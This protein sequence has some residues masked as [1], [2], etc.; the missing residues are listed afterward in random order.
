VEDDRDISQAG[1][2]A[3][4]GSAFN[5]K[6][7]GVSMR[8]FKDA[9]GREWKIGVTV[10]SVKRVK[11][12]AKFDL[13]RVRD[14][15]VSLTTDPELLANVLCAICRPQ[16]E[17]LGISDEEFGEGL[18]GDP[19]DHATRALLE[20]LADFFPQPAQRAALHKLLVTMD[21]VTARGMDL[22]T[23]KMDAA[24]PAKRT[25][26]IAKMEEILGGLFTNLPG[27]S[28][29]TPDLSRSAS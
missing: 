9:K 19:I 14:H 25:E 2:I 4:T 23:T 28:A 17:A 20:D 10:S 29:S 18:A 1:P 15:L 21:E 27:S 5:G 7:E 6:N 12:L 8:T 11:D 22:I 26:A 13:L 3:R 24:I 16:L